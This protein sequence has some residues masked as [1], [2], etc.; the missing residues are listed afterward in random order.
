MLV[1]VAEDQSA[2]L[3]GNTTGDNT[4]T[5]TSLAGVW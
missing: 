3:T 4:A 5:D 1:P 2:L